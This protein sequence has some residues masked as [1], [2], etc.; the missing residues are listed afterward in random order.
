MSSAHRYYKNEEDAVSICNAAFLKIVTKIGT[1]QDKV[2]FKA[3]IRRIVLNEIID[4][5][6]K[7]KKR[8]DLILS[9]HEDQEEE[10]QYSDIDYNIEAEYLENML[11]ELPK[12]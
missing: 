2:P 11:K 9:M 1:Y 3:W 6:L 10:I 5:Y 4:E 7:N 12:A 8:N